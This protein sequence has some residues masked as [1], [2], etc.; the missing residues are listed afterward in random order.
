MITGEEEENGKN[1]QNAYTSINP[2]IETCYIEKTKHL[3]HLEAANRFI[4]FMNIYL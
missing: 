3:P 2:S 1:V 4:E